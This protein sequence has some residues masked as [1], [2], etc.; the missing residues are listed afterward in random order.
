MKEAGYR[1]GL[2]IEQFCRGMRKRGYG[3]AWGTG[4]KMMENGC[5]TVLK[6]KEISDMLFNE[7][8]VYIP[9]LELMGWVEI[10][11][12]DRIKEGEV[13]EI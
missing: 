2:T 1:M 9:H 13:E 5:H 6:A 10:E 11:G 7:Y 8:G 4:Q 3:Y 12:M